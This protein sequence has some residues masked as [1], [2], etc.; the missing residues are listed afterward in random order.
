MLLA[1]ASF[2]RCSHGRSP[3]WADV[4]AMNGL[5]GVIGIARVQVRLT[6]VPQRRLL[7]GRFWHRA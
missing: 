7:N 3:T 2:S 5:A 1:L 6:S 4:A